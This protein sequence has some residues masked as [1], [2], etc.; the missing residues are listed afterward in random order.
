MHRCSRR[1]WLPAS[2]VETSR[3]TTR[4]SAST[5]D[6]FRQFEIV[7]SVDESVVGIEDRDLV[8]LSTRTEAWQSLVPKS[9]AWTFPMT[10]CAR[11][12]A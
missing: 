7:E 3:S 9:Q 5:L 2:R 6:D 10:E 8:F 1:P 11:H 12:P 4:T